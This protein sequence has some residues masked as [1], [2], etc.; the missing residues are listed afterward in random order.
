MSVHELKRKPVKVN[1]E[2]TFDG[3]TVERGCKTII[4]PPGQRVPASEHYRCYS[5]GTVWLTYMEWDEDYKTEHYSDGLYCYTCQTREGHV[6][7][8]SVCRSQPDPEYYP[9][10][11]LKL[12]FLLLSGGIPSDYDPRS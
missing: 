4:I 5:C 12:D 7:P 10:E 9:I 1:Y 3:Q 2:W 8:V 6:R 11:I